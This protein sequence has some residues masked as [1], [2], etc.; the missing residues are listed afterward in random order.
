MEVSYLP[1]PVLPVVSRPWNG[2]VMER[3]LLPEVQRYQ[4]D[5]ILNYV[6]Y[7]DG[8][9]AV[10]IARA[11]GV[12][13]VLTAIGSDLNRISGAL[14]GV[15]TRQALRRADGMLTVSHDLART[16]M[17]MGAR[18]GTTEALLNGCDTAVFYPHDRGEARAAL[19]VA[20]EEEVILYVGRLDVRKGL[21][22]L[23]EAMAGLRERRPLVR[24][25][26]VGD[27]PDRPLLV[28]AIGRV[29]AEGVVR[30]VPSCLTAEVARWI[31]AADLVTLPS[32]MEG[33]PN[34]VIE[35]LSS[36]RPVVA[37]E[38]GGIPELMDARSGRL[39]PAKD[40]AALRVG[41]DEVLEQRWDAEEIASRHSRSW[42]EL[43]E[44]V[45][46]VL[47]RTVAR[48]MAPL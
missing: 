48:G 24:A 46:G 25:Y 37:T 34:V 7:P 2:F 14:T 27:G 20:A 23:I 1:Y 18:A 11:L 47:E 19:G 30:L 39:V 12:P 31:G 9:A 41:L 43:A 42:E 32:Y 28:E 6:V 17:K 3:A 36:G 4:P 44:Q 38:V 22:E 10:R 13:V 26:L 8:Y 15:W 40:G 16:A 29:G 21:V 33:C 5:M 45:F 35:A